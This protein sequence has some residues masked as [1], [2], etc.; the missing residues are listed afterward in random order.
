MRCL[1]PP[2]KEKIGPKNDYGPSKT[3]L[4]SKFDMKDMSLADVILVVKITK[5]S[6]GLS[7]SQT[8][9]IDKILEKFNKFDSN[10]TRTHIYV[11][12]HLS[13]NGGRRILIGVFSYN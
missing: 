10:I 11:N 6:N 9:Y 4:N 8:H 3:M 5:T 2:K 12:P 13:K 7:L 1:A